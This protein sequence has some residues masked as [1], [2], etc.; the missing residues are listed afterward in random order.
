MKEANEYESRTE[1]T[2]AEIAQDEVDRI[3]AEA[4]KFE[5][6]ANRPLLVAHLNSGKVVYAS[7]MLD[8]HLGFSHEEYKRGGREWAA[9]RFILKGNEDW[10]AEI[11]KWRRDF[12]VNCQSTPN[13]TPSPYYAYD[14]EAFNPGTELTHTVVVRSS[15]L[16]LSEHGEIFL[17]T[18]FFDISALKRSKRLFFHLS[19]PWNSETYLKELDSGDFRTEKHLLSNAECELVR[20]LRVVPPAQAAER[21]GLKPGTIQTKLKMLCRKTDAVGLHGL[22][23]ICNAMGW[24]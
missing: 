24:C 16:R 2:S 8:K 22:V 21:L 17:G 1:A 12:F 9:Q 11:E 5:T 20:L 23:Q 14:L 18:T 3:V 10:L 7:N 15:C 4:T 6:L 19:A 13:Q